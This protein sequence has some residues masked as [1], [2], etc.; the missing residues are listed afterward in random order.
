VQI[1]SADEV[2]NCPLCT[3]ENRGDAMFCSMCGEQLQPGGEPPVATSIPQAT[4][5]LKVVSSIRSPDVPVLQSVP[6]PLAT[7][8]YTRN[9]SNGGGRQATTTTAAASAA[10]AVGFEAI[11]DEPEPVSGPYARSDTPSPP[12]F[13]YS[14][15]ECDGRRVPVVV[16]EQWISCVHCTMDNPPEATRCEVCYGLLVGHSHTTV[17]RGG[18]AVATRADTVAAA[19]LSG[20]F[21]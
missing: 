11:V 17:G 19:R 20:R 14:V 15:V 2:V 7:D 3:F 13:P 6:V 8:P 12:P 21:R 9:S 4:P 10:R 1:R 18:A 16:A 5:S